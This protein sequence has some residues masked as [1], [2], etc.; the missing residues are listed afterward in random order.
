L[1]ATT[2]LPERLVGKPCL[3]NLSANLIS[4]ARSQVSQRIVPGPLREAAMS[5]WQ[6]AQ[7]RWQNEVGTQKPDKGIKQPVS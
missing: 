3:G 2:S 7:Q 1:S 6:C 4:Q 5:Q